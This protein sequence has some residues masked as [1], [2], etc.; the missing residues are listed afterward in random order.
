M[1]QTL[2]RLQLDLDDAVA[3]RDQALA[4]AE[5]QTALL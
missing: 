2:R 4:E 3:T 1:H 5:Q